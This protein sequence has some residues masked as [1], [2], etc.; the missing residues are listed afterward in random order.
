MNI[1]AQAI[2]PTVLWIGRVISGLAITFLL[3]DAAMK[4]VPLKPV[5]DAMQELGFAGSDPLARGLGVLLL[6]CTILYAIPSTAPLGAL[7]LT[8][9]L[10]G[11]I[12]V[13]LQ[14]GNPVFSH[15]LFGGYIGLAVWAGLLLRSSHLR[16]VLIPSTP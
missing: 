2:T 7:L 8:G 16:S 11:A 3:L 13:Q 15:V 6:G 1:E 10:G 12:A 9:Y 14:A 4:L 5:I